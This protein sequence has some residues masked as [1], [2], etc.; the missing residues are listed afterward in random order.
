MSINPMGQDE[1]ELYVPPWE[2]KDPNVRKF[3]ED[4]QENRTLDQIIIAEFQQIEKSM[5]EKQFK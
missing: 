3:Y 5:R 2:S 4:S 1:L